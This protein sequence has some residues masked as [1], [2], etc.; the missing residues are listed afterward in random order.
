M[1]HLLELNHLFE[2]LGLHSTDA[3]HLKTSLER[4]IDAT[5]VS[6]AGIAVQLLLGHDIV[7]TAPV[8][9]TKI[10]GNWFDPFLIP[11]T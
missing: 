8:E 3:E 6:K 11:R 9:Q 4:N 7:D 5:T 10:D 1:P 2:S